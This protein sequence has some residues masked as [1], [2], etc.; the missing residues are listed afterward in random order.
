[1]M[2][3]TPYITIMSTR[4][5]VTSMV[6]DKATKMRET[7]RLMSLSRMSYMLSFF[8]YQAIL[9]L[10]SGVIVGGI[11]FNNSIAFP[12]EDTRFNNSIGYMLAVILLCLGM[13]GFSMAFST[14]FY[15][16]KVAQNM[17]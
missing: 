13:I 6:E 11:L 15:D 3:Y 7:L 8:V 12:D 5:I 2:F 16:T 10:W 9:S 4:F 1:M 14:L 17:T